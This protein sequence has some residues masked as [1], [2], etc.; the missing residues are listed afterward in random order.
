VA[1]IRIEVFG[2]VPLIISS[3]EGSYVVVKVDIQ[4]VRG[5]MYWTNRWLLNLAGPQLVSQA[6]VLAIANEE[7]Q[8]HA[9]TVTIISGRVSDM[10]VG[11]DNFYIYPMNIPGTIADGG[12]PL[13]GWVTLRADFGV[14]AGRPLRKYWRVYLGENQVVG[15]VWSPG[16]LLAVKDRMEELLTLVPTICDPQGN[17]ATSV[18]AKSQLQMR[19][20]RRGTKK[21]LLPVIPIA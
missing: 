10:V 14:G 20:L 8:L 7:S 21:R 18:A 9:T 6:M 3:E 15:G 16:I 4:K 19:Q 1:R 11:T 13:P 5:G 17:E 12:D 2:Y